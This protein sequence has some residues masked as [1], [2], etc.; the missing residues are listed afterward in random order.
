MRIRSGFNFSCKIIIDSSHQIGSIK[1]PISGFPVLLIKLIKRL[2]E[3]RSTDLQ[4]DKRTITKNVFIFH[5]F[6]FVNI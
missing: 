1:I 4:T 5:V 6:S 2:N 3:E